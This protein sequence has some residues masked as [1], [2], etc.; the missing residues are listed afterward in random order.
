M[1]LTSLFAESVLLSIM[2]RAIL[3]ATVLLACAWILARQAGARNA[4]LRSHIWTTAVMLALLIPSFSLLC[5]H[6]AWMLVDLPAD[7]LSASGDVQREP[8]GVAM[9]LGGEASGVMQSGYTVAEESSRHVLDSQE[10]SRPASLV[11]PTKDMAGSA[12]STKH[13]LKKDRGFD[14]R[15]AAGSL[16]AIWV[17][18]VALGLIRL[19]I[20]VC[21]VNRLF[22]SVYP[23][24]PTR[25]AR[26]APH[27]RRAVGPSR[28]PRIVVSQEA[29]TALSVFRGFRGTVIL[30]AKMLDELSDNELKDV[31]T[32]ECVHLLKHDPIIGLLQSVAG[33]LYWPH[34]LIHVANRALTR[35][36]EEV[37]DN[38]VLR[39][40]DAVGYAKT[41]L[42]IAERRV[43]GTSL[44]GVS[45]L[46]SHIWRLEDRIE[47]LL[48]EE[49]STRVAVSRRTGVSVVALLCCFAVA[50]GFVRFGSAQRQESGGN[51]AAAKDEHAHEMWHP[52]SL[53]AVVGDERGRKWS[54][55]GR[56]FDVHPD[57]EQVAAGGYRGVI[58]LWN[59]KTMRL[60]HLLTGH[61]GSV[62]ALHYSPD[63]RR[64]ISIGDDKSIFAWD[65]SAEGKPHSAKIGSFDDNPHRTVW[66]ADGSTVLI[67]QDIWQYSN[68][69]G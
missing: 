40:A 4:A 69:G 31:V 29:S 49:R 62:R 21:R 57:G 63:G 7:W 60:E 14:T 53:V 51:E 27:V 34:P 36:R 2:M 26:I 37:C 67:A 38:Y 10:R 8:A 24:S 56:G 55:A 44:A 52:Q 35:S 12:V 39:S 66:S 64:L 50:G 16:F 30:P 46:S 47:G 65:L 13:P 15:R 68:R 22:R 1:P 5:E 58:F 41:L 17:C 6:Q 33:V 45:P 42:G 19:V 61:D 18:G 23:L 25:L 59:A 20:A 48:E 43:M 32:H 3:L 9:P 54:R 28:L 11:K